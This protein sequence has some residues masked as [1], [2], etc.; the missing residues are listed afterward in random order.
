MGEM[1]ETFRAWVLAQEVDGCTMAQDGDAVRITAEGVNGS[2]GFYHLDDSD[3]VELRL[4]DADSGDSIFFLHFEMKDLERAKQLFQEMVEALGEELSQETTHVLLCCTCGITTT[5]F[6]TKLN[7]RAE[8]L[9]L[10][11]DFCAKSLDEA[12]RS[13]NDYAAVLLAPQVGYERDAVAEACPDAVVIELPGKIFGS[14]DA[15]G[16]LRLVVDAL[17]GAHSAETA[18]RRLTLARDYDMR[19]R[20]LALSY[21]LRSDEPTL[22]WRVFEN[23]EV[24]DSGM[25]IRKTLDPSMVTD[26]AATLRVR[27]FEMASFEMVGVAVPNVVDGDEVE[28][29]G[30]RVALASSLG[31]Q[32]GVPVRVDACVEAAAA[33]CY[34]AQSEYENVAFHAQALGDAACEQGYVIDGHTYKGR[35]GAAGRLGQLK[36]FFMYGMTAQEAA[37]RVECVRKLVARYLAVTVTTVAPEAIYVWCDLLP[38]MD[39]LRSELRRVLPPKSIPP[40]FPVADYDGTVLM[41][42]L[43][44]CL[45]QLA[46]EAS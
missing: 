8:E 9:G 15:D 37:W 43:A 46:E 33:G 23:G 38:E 21:V 42:E 7:E 3:V 19:R 27:G 10:R 25:L 22:S 6:A 16:A 29:F 20:I 45:Q 17:E 40:L 41:G 32:W 34:V 5:Y 24:A 18:D 30:E 12:K 11:Y 44:L 35:G 28:V 26:F 2:V 31:E 1:A 4:E 36:D 14:Y 39:E 13:G